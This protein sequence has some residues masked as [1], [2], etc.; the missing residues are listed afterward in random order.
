MIIAAVPDIFAII[1]AV[2]WKLMMPNRRQ[3]GFA[4]VYVN[5]DGSVRQLSGEEQAYLARRFEV[6]DSARPYI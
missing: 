4:F 1:G 2:I 6:G 5:R 3:T